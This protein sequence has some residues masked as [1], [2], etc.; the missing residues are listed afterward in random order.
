MAID[1]PNDPEVDQTYTN[2]LRTWK[3]NGSTWVNQSIVT[4]ATGPTGP[5]GPT[6]PEGVGGGGGVAAEEWTDITVTDDI[7]FNSS[8][9]KLVMSTNWSPQ[10]INIPT[11]P[12][13]GQVTLFVELT[14][15]ASIT[16]MDDVIWLTALP[17]PVNGEWFIVEFLTINGR[18]CAS[19]I[20]SGN[21]ADPFPE[22]VTPSWR[23]F[24]WLANW[25][26]V[27]TN[28]IDGDQVFKVRDAANNYDLLMP[29]SGSRPLYR[30]A[31]SKMNGLPALEFD[32][33]DD[34]M[35]AYGM[36]IAQPFSIV[37]VI[38]TDQADYV[39]NFL[40]INSSTTD[41]GIGTTNTSSGQ[42]K[43][44]AS[45]TGNQGGQPVVDTRYLIEAYYNGTSSYLY[46]NGHLITSGVTPGTAGFDQ[47][48]MGA[49]WA[50][51]PGNFWDGSIALMAI[52][53][54]EIRSASGWGTVRDDIIADYDITYTAAPVVSSPS[55]FGWS[56]DL[57][58]DS[59]AASN[60]ANVEGVWRD[61]SGNG[62]H[63]YQ[64]Y[65][66]YRPLKIASLAAVNN[67]AVF[68]FNGS[69]M[70]MVHRQ[71][72]TV[73]APWSALVVFVPDLAD[74]GGRLVGTSDASSARGFGQSSTSTGRF[75]MA[76][77]GSGSLES[78]SPV[79]GTA[80]LM[81]V[82]SNGSSSYIKVNGTTLITGS[83]GA[84]PAVNMVCIGAGLT[85]ATPGSYFDG[86][87]ATVKF[88]VGGNHVD[89]TGWATEY[90]TIK[91]KYGFGF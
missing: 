81:E 15:S 54:G 78:G 34:F 52:Y 16:W 32:G 73:T 46:V 18:V 22:S 76:L 89:H 36:T 80:Y 31:H 70:F 61:D 72:S 7:D 14:G 90:A 17:A 87:I 91:T 11:Y 23:A 43:A 51:T 21:D 13:V 86:K 35:R 38:Q 45:A 55:T 67:Q 68:D 10:F 44:Y 25:E 9:L 47:F 42:W 66:N 37:A 84:T 82:Y 53:E 79:A 74:S 33:T 12:D 3:W 48:V 58:A 28:G 57:N 83:A 77:G 65:V 59:S 8:M 6:G 27:N 71:L 41:R 1:F 24:D 63:V 20:G 85:T 62:L 19:L 88:F 30:A 69:S 56:I 29:V 50:G 40:G 64:D 5:A 26:A 39:S 75:Q 49:G 4:G 2:G 60:G